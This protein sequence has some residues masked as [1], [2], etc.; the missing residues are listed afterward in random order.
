MNH[1]STLNDRLTGSAGY[2]VWESNLAEQCG[3][4]HP[5]PPRSQGIESFEGLILPAHMAAPG[6][7][8]AKIGTNCPHIHRSVN[9]IK[10]DGRDFFYIVH[11][12]TGNAV[13]DHCGTQS[14]LTPGDLV[15]L[16]S[17]RPSDFYFSGMSEQISILIPRHKFESNTKNSKLILNQKIRAVSKIG[18]VAGF[19][20]NQLFNDNDTGEDIEAIMDSLISLIRPTFT[21]SDNQPSTYNEKIQKSYFEKA[22]RCIEAQLSNFELTPEKIAIELGT[23]KRT[24]HRIFAQQGLS[25]GRYIL[26]RRLDKCA[27]EFET[28]DD[29]QKISAVAFAWGF[30]DVSHFSRAFKSRFG[31]SPRG[32]RS[33]AS[34]ITH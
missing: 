31:V 27:A 33:K 8:G 17:S 26:D 20:A 19:I 1:H 14:V 32:Y 10:R 16:D 13:M 5:E 29:I 6:Y 34:S 7:A 24:L 28:E 18:A 9:D 23:S 25:I 2:Q 15:L 22:Q 30:N 3:A 21:I 11:Q 4:F 12:V